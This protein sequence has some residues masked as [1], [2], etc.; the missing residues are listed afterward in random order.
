MKSGYLIC[1][2]RLCVYTT[3]HIAIY[4]YIWP[5]VNTAI[6][7]D[8]HKPICYTCGALLFLTSMFHFVSG[9]DHSLSIS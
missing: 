9:F 4:T 5:S 1:L 3:I 7:I 6:R 2:S 8:E